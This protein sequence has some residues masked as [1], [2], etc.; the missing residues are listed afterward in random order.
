MPPLTRR[1]ARDTI[2]K[3]GTALGI[4]LLSGCA[5]TGPNHV[6][7][8]ATVEPGI[9]RDLGPEARWDLPSFIAPGEKLTGLA[10]D[11]FTDHIFL[12]LSPGN[13][14][15]VIDRPARKVKR[16]FVINEL[17]A[18]GGGDLAV[19]PRDGHIFFT[20]PATPVL[21]ETNRLG[22]FVR[23]IHL[24]RLEKPPVGVAYDSARNRL[25]VLY[26]SHYPVLGFH[27]L[28]GN[29]LHSVSLDYEGARGALAYDSANGE[30]YAPGCLEAV[31]TVFNEEGK[32]LRQLP[33][34]DGELAEFIDAGPRSFVRIF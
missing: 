22:A 16:E 33:T 4:V 30:I 6:Y 8:A 18:S 5:T 10:Y 3:L 11:P 27:D 25:L 14:I 32:V 23:Q 12:R 20:H 29:L 15:R 24:A 19:R 9:V 13:R 26:D 7:A 21:I 1:L 34:P 31:I 17:P 2:R 28:A